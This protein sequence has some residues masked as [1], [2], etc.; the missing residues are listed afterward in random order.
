MIWEIISC[1]GCTESTHTHTHTHTNTHTHTYTY[2]YTYT[3]TING[4]GSGLRTPLTKML[5]TS[6]GTKG[7]DPSSVQHDV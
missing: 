3:H 6:E 2:T 4:T 5:L 1:V 7:T